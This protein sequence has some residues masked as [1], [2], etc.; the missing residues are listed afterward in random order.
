MANSQVQATEAY[1]TTING[2]S[3]TEA[4]DLIKPENRLN[5]SKIAVIGMQTTY[6]AHAMMTDS[7]SLAF[8]LCYYYPLPGLPALRPC[9]PLSSQP[10]YYGSYF[11]RCCCTASHHCPPAWVSG[12]NRRG[13]ST[14]TGSML[15]VLLTC[16]LAVWL[17][18]VFA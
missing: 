4:S 3:A 14:Y 1:L 2:G 17:D 16:G 6:D 12:L 13:T 10:W 7:A 5:M 8:L 9:S 11:F 15:G 18:K